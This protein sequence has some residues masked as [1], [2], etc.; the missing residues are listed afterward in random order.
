MSLSIC[1][2]LILILLLLPEFAFAKG[3]QRELAPA[4]GI[5]ANYRKLNQ[6]ELGRARQTLQD[7]RGFIWLVGDNGVLR[8]DGSQTLAIDFTQQFLKGAKPPRIES[9][10]IDDNQQ[11]WLMSA[12]QGLFKY[13]QRTR[14]LQQFTLAELGMDGPAISLV[15]DRDGALWLAGKTQLARLENPSGQWQRLTQLYGHTIPP[16]IHIK[17]IFVDSRMR[18]WLISEN[19]G[20]FRFSPTQ[21]PNHYTMHDGTLASNGILSVFEDAEQ[22]LWFGTTAGIAR[23]DESRNRFEIFPISTGQPTGYDQLISAFAERDQTH[24]WLGSLSHGVLLF[25]RQT[26]QVTPYSGPDDF[27]LNT[28]E[29]NHLLVDSQQSLW[30]STEAGVSVS[31]TAERHIKHWPI[32]TQQ[33]CNPVGMAAIEPSVYFGCGKV[34]YRWHRSQHEVSEVA[35]FDHEILTLTATKDKQLWLGMLAGGLVRYD[36]NLAQR[37]RYSLAQG[38]QQTANSVLLLSIDSHQ[39]LWGATFDFQNH[40]ARH[41]F[42]YD[43]TTDALVRFPVSINPTTLTEQD[44]D[45]WLLSGFMDD[46][47]Y[48]FDKTNGSLTTLQLNT[49]TIYSALNDGSHIWLGTDRLGLVR[50]EPNTQALIPQDNSA[51][52]PFG[53]ISDNNGGVFF[54]D[55]DKLYHFDGKD[56]QCLSCRQHFLPLTR[57]YRGS[58]GW[59]DGQLLIGSQNRFITLAQDIF[60]EKLPPPQ[61]YFSDLSLFNRK[62]LPR[63]LTA[64]SPLPQ[65]MEYLQ[66]LLVL[67][68]RD[69][70]FSI[71]FGALSLQ[72]AQHITYFYRLAGI[73]RLQQD[74][75]AAPKQLPAATFSTLPAGRYRLEVKAINQLD[76]QTGQQQLKF[77]IEPAPWLSGPAKLGYLM[78]ALAGIYAFYRWRTRSLQRRATQLQRGIEARTFE[79]NQSNQLLSEKNATI[80]LLLSQKRQMFANM[81]HEFRTPLT[82]ILS[83]LERLLKATLSQTH[84]KYLTI[85]ER[86]TR[87]L[88]N[89]VEQLLQ[90]AQLESSNSQQRRRYQVNRCI[91]YVISSFETLAL[92]KNLSVST[93]FEAECYADLVADSLE[94]ITANLLSNAIKYTPNGG[95]IVLTVSHQEQQFTL[96]VCDSGYG[97][98]QDAQR[99]IFEPFSRDLSGGKNTAVGSG[100]GLALVKQ[101]VEVNEGHIVLNSALKRGSCFSVTLPLAPSAKASSAPDA[102]MTL[103]G[104]SKATLYD[105]FDAQ[106]DN[107]TN[108]PQPIIQLQSTVEQKPQLVL[109][110]D[111]QD[112]RE[113]LFEILS[114]E[115]HCLPASAGIEG[116]NLVTEQIPDLVMCDLMMPDIDGLQV[117]RR[118][119]SDERT[120]HIP[121]LLLTAKSDV[122][123]RI[124]GWRHNIDDFVAKPFVEAELRAKLL[125]LLSIRRILAKRYAADRQTP[126]PSKQPCSLNEKDAAFLAR[127]SNVVNEHLC[128]ERFNRAK[129]AGLLAVSERQLQRKLAA[130]TDYNFTDFVRSER[131]NQAQQLLAEGFQVSQ[132]VEKTG[133]SSISYFGT[134]FKAEFG[135]TPKQYQMRQRTQPQSPNL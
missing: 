120:S 98:D 111:N 72:E 73:E 122:E 17:R 1:F 71:H 11:L 74:W 41:L 130:L 59:F 102:E 78:I 100:I 115:F 129:A 135:M 52:A 37:K 58:L 123:T 10:V 117:C 15:K 99:R 43:R 103:S 76:G 38:Q 84:H 92:D 128:D 132:I 6:I 91:K 68:H 69:E 112:M 65:A 18:V 114:D 4:G 87:L 57:L 7:E 94:T 119:K 22:Q 12:E 75:L 89:M 81:S 40:Q 83:P 46:S 104:P 28:Q 47:L 126:F 85:I 106:N 127:F 56:K 124:S 107:S 82:L 25:N 8:F 9:M 14:Q 16:D 60:D 109:I 118:L 5:F 90:L 113:Y 44:E 54:H 80:S 34:L 70:L 30:V 93:H 27:S 33:E 77:R 64:D 121:I 63:P 20:L 95:N 48:L 49:G 13:R 97:I 21:E 19:Q 51:S 35:R 23:F 108:T 45:Q 105:H 131:L 101:L 31:T 2:R 66:Q 55:K 133:F 86:N 24:L 134:C 62:V 29:V 3:E 32:D 26:R 36:L 50:Y 61:V 116:I 67:S 39:Q 53:L 110:E 125:N 96:E 42:Y 79:L 88:V